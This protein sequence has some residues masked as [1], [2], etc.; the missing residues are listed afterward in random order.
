MN[1][2]ESVGNM[3]L[4]ETIKKIRKDKGLS[5][6]EVSSGYLSQSNYSKFEKGDIEIPFTTFIGIL[7]NLNIGLEEL[8]YIDNEYSYSEKEK[9]Y[10]EFFRTPVNNK[11]ILE[12]LILK[13]ETFLDNYSDQLVSFIHKICVILN[14]SLEQNDIYFNKN[15]A[16]CL[17]EVFSKKE[18]LY[19]KDI[20][21][22]NSIFFL[23]PIETARLTMEYIGTALEK[24]DD[25]HSIN[26]LAVNLR[27]NYSLMLLKSGCETDALIQ[28]EKALPLTQKYKLSVQMAILYIRMGICYNNLNIKLNTDFIQKGLNILEVLE[29]IEVLEIMEKEILNYLKYVRKEGI[30]QESEKR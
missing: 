14:N 1:R 21:I 9:I 23:F 25:F 17:L 20:Y 12:N 7:N 24:Y 26:R 2:N 10:R 30:L 11:K 6:Q 4:Y 19:E 27:M 28:L 16:L 3:V 5:Q 29:E 8:L 13:C 18:N 15:T 22:I